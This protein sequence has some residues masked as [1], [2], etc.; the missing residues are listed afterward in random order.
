VPLQYVICEL[1]R[2][3]SSSGHVMDAARV[4]A[5]ASDG[6]VGEL[7]A[8]LA[9]SAGPICDRSRWREGAG[10]GGPNSNHYN[11]VLAA[12]TP[13]APVEDGADTIV[14]EAKLVRPATSR[15]LDV[16]ANVASPQGIQHNRSALVNACDGF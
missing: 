3:Q 13:R 16:V 1:L 8:A 5:R 12:A 15:H 4:D 6:W 11:K 14:D 9:A 10:F 7:P 2:D